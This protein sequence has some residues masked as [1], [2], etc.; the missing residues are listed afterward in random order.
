MPIHSTVD[1]SAGR[2]ADVAHKFLDKP[3]ADSFADLFSTFSPQLVAFFRV[4]GCELDLAE[5]LAQEVMFTVHRKAAQV[6]ARA[7]FRPWLFKIARNTLCRHYRKQ[8]C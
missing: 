7:L 2:E 6:R 3:N 1:D 5:D 8:T 4:R